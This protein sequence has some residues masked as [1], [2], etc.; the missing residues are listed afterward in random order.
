MYDWLN[1]YLR[2]PSG[3]Y[4]DRITPDGRIERTHF[5]YNQG[6]MIGANVLRYRITGD[7]AYL[8]EAE[9]IADASLRLFGNREFGWQDP[10]LN[11]IFFKYALLLESA[12]NRTHYREV[13]Q[14]Y[15][16]Q[17]W[18]TTVDPTTLL[19]E[20]DPGG[21]VRLLAQSVIVQLHAYLDWNRRDLRNLG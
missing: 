12:N 7:S 2:A 10:A 15:A 14:A 16:D 6:A 19:V 11:A 18:T 4:W 21:G 9:R 17:L 8:R 3:L 1:T 13:M 20:Q 5:S